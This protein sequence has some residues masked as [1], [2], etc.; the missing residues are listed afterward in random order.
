MLGRERSSAM[1]RSRWAA[2]GAAVA[3]AVGAGGAGW[4]AHAAESSAPSTFVS[5]TPCRLFD[6]RPDTAVGDRV[7]PLNAGEELVRQVTGT[8]GSCNIPTSA[9]GIAYN[10]TVPTSINGFLTVFPADAGR[11]NSSAVNPVAGESVK[12][13]GGIVGLSA[14][15]AIKVYTLTGPLDALLDI[16]GYF[17]STGTDGGDGGVQQVIRSGQTV[18]G[19]VDL[20]AHSPGDT[21]SD[22]LGEDLPGIAPVPLTDPTVNFNPGSGAQDEDPAC[23]GTDEAPT[24]PPGKLCVYLSSWTN[25][26]VSS[27]RAFP[28]IL[29]N[30]TFFIRWTPD[31]PANQDM[32]LSV[33]WAYTA[34]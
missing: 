15:G 17:V 30:L 2:I 33:T 8:N 27:L 16:T 19:S 10:L 32:Y 1:S 20:D 13:N 34:P 3:V 5:I 14:G 9:T 18:F 28:G 26:D 4:M 25:V 24:A 12:A 29:K 6:T 22:L 21:V 7:T 11:P 31:G 23:T